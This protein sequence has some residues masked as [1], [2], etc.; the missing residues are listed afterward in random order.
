MKP[1]C[2]ILFMSAALAAAEEIALKADRVAHVLVLKEVYLNDQG[3][4]RM[5]IDTGAASCLI[6]PAIAR[7]LGLRPVYAVA[8]DTAAG[9]KRVPAALLEVRVGSASDQAVE[10]MVTDVELPGVDGVLGQSW[11]ARHDYLLDYHGRRLVLDAAAPGRGVR[12]A[13]CSSDG[14]PGISAEVNG[15]QQD[16]V[17][18]SGASMLILF[19]R[20]ALAG[21]T[22]L[23]TNRGSLDATRATARVRIGGDYTRL[24]T[25]AEVNA[26][27]KPGL[28][29]AAAFASVYIS[30]RDGVVV[31]VP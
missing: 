10:A 28:L 6:R 4:F 29:P 21:T 16:L 8:H 27:P 12:A 24:M 13:L 5:M 31:L 9:L 14:R 23:V 1:A 30:N 20:P 3:P 19:G 17:V 26:S 22:V 15:R 2:L 18:D 25:T 7:K 11:L